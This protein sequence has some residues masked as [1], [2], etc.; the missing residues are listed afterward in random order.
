MLTFTST[1][2]LLPNVYTPFFM[3]LHFWTT[4]VVAMTYILTCFISQNYKKCCILYIITNFC[5]NRN[6]FII[7]LRRSFDFTDMRIDE[8]L[9]LYLETFRLPGESPLISLIMEHFAEHW[10]VSLQYFVCYAERSLDHVNI[11]CT[12]KVLLRY[13]LLLL[14]CSRLVQPLIPMMYSGGAKLP[15]LL[16]FFVVSLTP[17][18]KYHNGTPTFPIHYS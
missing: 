5:K 7:F 10:H 1:C 15:P 3:L 16:R 8:A 11:S 4:N 12:N 13:L 14:N 6:M 18:G 2:L 9:R 17:P